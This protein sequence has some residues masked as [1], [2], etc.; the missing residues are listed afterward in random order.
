VWQLVT[1]MALT[2]ATAVAVA[3][4]AARVYRRAL[5]VTD[6]RVKARDLVGT[7]H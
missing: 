1:A 5:L 3:A 2:G 4:L 6:R 7:S